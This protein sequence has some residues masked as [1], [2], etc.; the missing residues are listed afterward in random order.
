VLLCEIVR[1]GMFMLKNV[2]NRLDENESRKAAASNR[3]Q[4]WLQTYSS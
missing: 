4:N 1:T 2:N 3:Q